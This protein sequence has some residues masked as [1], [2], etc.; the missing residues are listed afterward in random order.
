MSFIYFQSLVN[1]LSRQACCILEDIATQY[2][3]L[4]PISMF[5]FQ[6]PSRLQGHKY[7]S[8]S[9]PIPKIP[10]LSSSPT[11]LFPMTL[12]LTASL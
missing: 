11:G 7:F 3:L 8:D 5:S 12:A 2:K 9:Q 4:Y 1:L 10:F 6:L